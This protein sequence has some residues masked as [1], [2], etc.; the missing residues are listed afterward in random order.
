MKPVRRFDP[1]RAQRTLL[2]SI[3]ALSGTLTV[4]A[5]ARSEPRSTA[6]SVL[7]AGQDGVTVVAQ[8]Q[9]RTVARTR[10]S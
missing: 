4:Y 8:T 3:A 5:V 1:L 10:G 2:L 6:S 9:R 7:S